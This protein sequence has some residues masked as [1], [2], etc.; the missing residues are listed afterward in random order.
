MICISGESSRALARSSHGAAVPAALLLLTV[1]GC[2]Y[3]PSFNILGSYFPSWLV[4]FAA[5]TV[6]TFLAH[7]LFTR[8]KLVHELW[9]LPLL[10]VALVSL[11]TCVLWI[12][13]FE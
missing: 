2:G 7:V 10:Y 6:L 13:F 5:A 3:P 1:T 11:F 12:I 8:T 9:P 4:C